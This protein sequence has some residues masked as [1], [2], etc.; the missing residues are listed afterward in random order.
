[1]NEAQKQVVSVLVL[2]LRSIMDEWEDDAS[3]EAFEIIARELDAGTKRMIDREFV[4]SR[5]SVASAHPNVMQ[6]TVP[7]CAFESDGERCKRRVHS[8]SRHDFINWET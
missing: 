5:Q 2:R 8:D 7:R 6:T 1:M 3:N 4:K